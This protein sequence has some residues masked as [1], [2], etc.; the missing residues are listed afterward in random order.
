MLTSMQG[1]VTMIYEV[2]N[3]KN[4]SALFGKWEETLIWSC[5][6][7]IMGKLYA[8]ELNNPTAT[9][10]ILGDFTFFAGK[11]NMELVSYKPD[12]CKQN[13][14]IMVPQ[15]EDWQNAIINC[16]DSKAKVVSRYAIKKEPDIFDREKLEKAISSLPKEYKLCMIDEQLYQMCK[17]ETW[18]A[19]LVSQFPDY[20]MYRK[21]GLGAVICKNNAVV[22]GAS[23]YSRYREGIEIEIDTKKEYRRKGLAYICGAKLILECLNRNLY[24]SWDAQNIFSVSLAEKL[25]YHYSHTYTAIEIWGY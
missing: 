1:S 25:G 10:A 4:I 17:A 19:D 3:S 2:T 5:L 11:P 15:N 23:S 14:M 18:S 7:G 13:F 12:W 8:D 16:Y 9:M 20:E 24:P 21:L 22:S 6:Q